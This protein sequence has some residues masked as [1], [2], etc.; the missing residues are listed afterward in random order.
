MSSTM[1][2]HACGGA[3]ISIGDK[4]FS[5]LENLGDGFCKIKYHYIDSSRANIDKIEPK[6]EFHQIRTKS[7]SIDEIAGSGAERKKFAIDIMANVKEYLDQNKYLQLVRSEFHVVVASASGGTGNICQSVIIRDLITRNIPTIAVVIGDSSNALSCINTINTLASLNS[8]AVNA[9]KALS[10]IYINNH[11]LAKGG[12]MNKAEENANKYLGN[13]MVSCSLFLS[14]DNEDLD[15]QDMAGI[16]DQSHYSTI[17]VQPGL[18]GLTFFSKD[19]VPTEGTIPTV[20]R[21]LSLPDKDFDPNLTLLHHKRGYVTAQNAIDIVKEENFP[22][23]MV[24][25]ANYFKQEEAS[26]KEQA[27]N[28]ENIMKN[29]EQSSVTGLES[30]VEDNATGLI[31]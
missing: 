12:N 1:I 24:A 8:I 22:L 19:I 15:N 21:T 10:V 16:I 25:F 11:T 20:G 2:V 31:F 30:S 7:N 17:K 9:K 28:Y 13:I 3:G 23:H 27:K 18:Y 6:G 4:V 14:G 5:K 26:L 29:I